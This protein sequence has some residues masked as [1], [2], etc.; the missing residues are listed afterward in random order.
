MGAWWKTFRIR[1]SSHPSTT[2]L[3]IAAS[4]L[5]IDHIMDCVHPD[6]DYTDAD[7]ARRRGVTLDE[8]GPDGMSRLT[9]LLTPEA[10]ATVEA[11]LATLAP[12]GMCNPD[13]EAPMLDGPVPEE[14]GMWKMTPFLPGR[15]QQYASGCLLELEGVGLCVARRVPAGWRVIGNL[16]RACQGVWIPHVVGGHSVGNNG[17]VRTGER[18]HGGIQCPLSVNQPRLRWLRCIGSDSY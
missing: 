14:T 6:G 8:Q 9:G 12:P 16:D 1:P 4:W 3:I 18:M 10:R 5:H 17:T 15:T 11:M 7:R 13:D 2:S